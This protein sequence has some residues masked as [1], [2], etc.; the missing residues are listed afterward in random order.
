[1][2]RH[3]PVLSNDPPPT[4]AGAGGS[5]DPGGE[6]EDETRPPWHWAG[7]GTVAIFAGWLP[8]AYVA[9]A[10]SARVMAARFG[11]DASRDAIDLALSAMS[12]GERAR[13]MATVALP[14]V[15]GLAL[16]AFG[17]G[18]VVGRFGS[19][20]QPAR[21]AAVS[22]AMTALVASAIAWGGFTVATLV[23]AAVTFGVAV[24]F[25]AWG[26]RFGA[27]RR[28]RPPGG[29]GAVSDRTEA[30]SGGG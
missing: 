5:A 2:R 24:G 16:A 30:D 21:V 9:G 22:G 4:P 27:S 13:L 7:F 25:A 11:E 29:S 20:A 3:L 15:L 26:G 23:A 19:G 6:G 28:P 18:V 12:A 1:M 14:S 17:G 10:V 8:L